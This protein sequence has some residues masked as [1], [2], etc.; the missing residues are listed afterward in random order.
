MNVIIGSRSH[1]DDECLDEIK[2]VKN[3]TAPEDVDDDVPYR[4]SYILSK[5]LVPSHS[6]RPLVPSLRH[7][8]SHSQ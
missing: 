1:D 5:G 8:G 3:D 7:L 6:S 4:H 2:E